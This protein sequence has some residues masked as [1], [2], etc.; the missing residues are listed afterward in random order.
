MLYHTLE[1]R[2]VIGGWALHPLDLSANVH[3][4]AIGDNS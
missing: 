3:E 4:N 1:E 2:F